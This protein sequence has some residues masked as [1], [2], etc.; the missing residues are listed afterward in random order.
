MSFGLRVF[1]FL[2]LLMVAMVSDGNKVTNNSSSENQEYITFRC[3]ASQK[4]KNLVLHGKKIQGACIKN[5][6][7]AIDAPGDKKNTK[8]LIYAQD[9]KVVN[10][11]ELKK[12]MTID[13]TA[14]AV[15]Q[16]DRI[17]VNYH[18]NRSYIDLNPL[19]KDS[20]P[21]LWTPYVYVSIDNMKIRRY[22]F[23]PITMQIGF[24]HGK[25][26]ND[27]PAISKIFPANSSLIWSNIAWSLTV[28][29]SYDFSSFPFDKN[30]C[31]FRMMFWNMDIIWQLENTTVWQLHNNSEPFNGPVQQHSDGFGIKMTLV[32][33]DKISATDNHYQTSIGFD[34]AIKRLKSKYIFQYYLPCCAIVATASFSFLIPFSAIPGRVALLVT[35]FLTLTSIFINVLVRMETFLHL[36][37]IMEVFL[38]SKFKNTV[39]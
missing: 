38:I 8:V 9:I 22:I 2:S 31:P 19:S 29:C 32:P 14:S 23:D 17:M 16:D 13:L 26:V 37:T 15:W 24:I 4:W 27:F 30:I 6:Y 34:I 20:M 7:Y 25:F 12:T 35:Q 21:E 33:P 39:K 28:S 36:G 5:D 18:E 3:N 10:V 1:H 11:D